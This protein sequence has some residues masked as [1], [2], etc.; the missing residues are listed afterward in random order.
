MFRV[1]SGF[2]VALLAITT[3]SPASAQAPT[4]VVSGTISSASAGNAAIN[5]AAVVIHLSSDSTVVAATTANPAGFF[6][7]N[8]LPAGSYYL[9]ISS[10]GFQTAT[11]DISLTSA[12]PNLALGIIELVP[13]AI[14]LAGVTATGQRS[15]VVLA[16]DRSIY[17][18][19]EM[20]LAQ[21]GIAIDAL[22]AVPELQV[23]I[24]DNI[25]ARGGEPLIFLDGRP[26]P[27]Q[28]EARLAFL[29]SLRADRIDRIEYIPNPSAAYEAE[30][31]T[32]IVN[33]VLRRDVGLG[34]SGSLSANAGTL[35]TQNMSGRVNFQEGMLTLFGGASMGFNQSRSSTY[36][37]REN[38]VASPV[39]FLEQ[40]SEFRQDGLNGGADLTAE[41]RL[42][43]R[44]TGWGI[45]RGNLGASED[46]DLS[47]FIHQNSSRTNT[48]WYERERER[49]A[50]NHN[51]SGA[52]GFRRV[53]ESQRNEMSAE[54]RYNRT[55]ND[56]G[57]DNLRNAFSLD[58]EPLDVAPDL[59][60]IDAR[61]RE[62]LLAFQFDVQRPIATG[63]RLDFGYRANFRVRNHRQNA[64]L[65]PGSGEGPE[66]QLDERF[67][68]DED[69][70]A[71]YL[72]VDQRLGQIA[73]QA[74]MRAERVEGENTATPLVAPVS[75]SELEFFPSANIAY[76][77][78]EGRQ[79]R[80]AYSRRV[81]R[82]SVS[83]YSPINTSPADPLN[84]TT[85]NPLLTPA[86]LHVVDGSLSWTGELGT[87]RINPYLAQGEGF[88]VSTRT[89]DANGVATM[90]PENV[91]SARA[92]GGGINASVRQIGPFSGF[93][94]INVEHVDFEAGNSSLIE[95][96]LMMWNSNANVTATLPGGARLQMTGGFAPAQDS[97]DGRTAMRRQANFA[98][99]QNILQNRGVVTLSVV[100]PFNLTQSTQFVQNASV[101]Q[102]SRSSNRV[103]RA[104]LTVTYNFGQAPQS[105]RRMVEE[106]SGGGGLGGS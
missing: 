11:R 44:V 66:W 72:S 79:L 87:L 33:I 74:G 25:R 58:G 5:G 30:G 52:I 23:D 63:T 31:Q 49:N 34:L 13:A 67:R 15:T 57:S 32:G 38:L 12:A 22:R 71:A 2:A 95:K 92:M 28:G 83:S 21:G 4:G 85:G 36:S 27:M 104:T 56:A 84:R 43:E 103:R 64:G 40:T 89:V 29:R 14:A 45:V 37:F 96:P 7:R 77:L 9:V 82:P 106:A 78:Q 68:Y 102:M 88:W 62:N 100:D 50:D 61:T 65:Y 48:D 99:T 53:I 101:D 3:L 55:S 20:P 54:L 86:Y 35:G 90:A 46:S 60:R 73:F 42:S 69:S 17:T 76:D 8:G 1:Y 80:I 70:H 97:P 6:S 91:A 24:D 19:R 26:L 94:N 98:L 41:L 81:Q 18:V 47:E 75:R 93:V 10:L 105:N 39:T 16:S 59:T 51:Y